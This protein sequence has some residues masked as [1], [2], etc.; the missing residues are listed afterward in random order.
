MRVSANVA[1]DLVR[2]G[3][4]RLRVDHPFWRPHAGQISQERG[5]LLKWQQSREKAQSA[6][7]ERL[8][9]VV[10]KQP[11]EQARQNFDRQEETGSAGDPSLAV[12][13]DPAAGDQTM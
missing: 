12:R 7:G 9:E 3:K 10:Q 8:V 4:R 2:T 11:A 6:S 13:R 1:E 5:T